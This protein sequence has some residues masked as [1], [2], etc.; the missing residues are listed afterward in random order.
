MGV[1]LKYVWLLA[2]MAGWFADPLAAQYPGQYPPGQY[3]GGGYPGGGISIPSRSHKKKDQDKDQANQPTIAADGQ[4]VSNDGKTLVVATNDGRT[5]TM[6]ITPKTKFTRSA[7]DIDGNKIIPRT[8][9]H[10]EAFEDD[11]A[12]LSAATVNLLKD[13]PQETPRAEQP[14]QSSSQAPLISR[15]T[16]RK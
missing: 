7:S 14:R 3:P 10:V 6:S 8:T 1:V 13:A 5:L 4:T 12:N 15:R 2:L 9:V 16:M 11:Q